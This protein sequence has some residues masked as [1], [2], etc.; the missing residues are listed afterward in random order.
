MAKIG[1]VHV[2]YGM[3]SLKKHEVVFT[4]RWDL[5]CFRHSDNILVYCLAGTKNYRNATAMA[6]YTQL[7]MQGQKG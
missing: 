5:Y 1:F 4:Y 3:F 2:Q 6:I 7:A